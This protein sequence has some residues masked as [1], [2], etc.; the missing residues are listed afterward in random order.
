MNK[1]KLKVLRRQ[2]RKKHIRKSIYGSADCLR[3]TVFRSLNHI[4]AQ[5]INDD[6]RRTLV[7]AST[8]DKEIRNLIKPEMKK[9]DLSKLVGATLAKRAIEANIKSVAFDRN[10]YIYHGRVK[11]L[12]DAA[13]ENG[14]E[15]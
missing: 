14:L 1:Q 3:L 10:S 4:Y 13:R 8:L 9:S 12:A 2:R 5:I 7:S 11:A 15:F 6:D